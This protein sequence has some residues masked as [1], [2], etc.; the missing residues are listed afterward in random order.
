MGVDPPRS[1]IE[2]TGQ[3]ATEVVGGL[4]GQPM[5]LALIVLNVLGISVAGWFLGKLVDIQHENMVNLL[6]I[7]FPNKVPQL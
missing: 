4:K 2:A 7:C 5:M 3:V 1:A 6:K